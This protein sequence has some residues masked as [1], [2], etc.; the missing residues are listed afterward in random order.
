[1]KSHSESNHNHKLLQ[2]IEHDDMKKSSSMDIAIHC[3]SKIKSMLID[4]LVISKVKLTILISKL[5]KDL[6]EIS[7]LLLNSTVFF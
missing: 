4:N 3:E 2:C 6:C 7:Q 1:M 5:L